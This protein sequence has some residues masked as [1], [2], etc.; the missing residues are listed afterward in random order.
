[1]LLLLA[2]SVSAFAQTAN[3]PAKAQ[4]RQG[5]AKIVKALDLNKDQAKQVRDIVAKLHQDVANV[6]KS[7]A[8]KD[9]KKAQIKDLRT[10]AVDAVMAI[11][12]PD[13]QTKAKKMNLEQMI[14]A[15]SSAKR[16]GVMYALSQLNLTDQQKASI[17]S[18]NEDSRKAAKAIQDD[19]SL[20]K[21]AKRAKLA[22]LKKSTEDKVVA[23]LTPDQQQKLKD[24]LAKEKQAAKD[25]EKSK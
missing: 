19:T 10:K 23:V 3:A 24:I 11:L 20:D 8:T 5:V 22:D 18:I 14:M 6:V 21:A 17:K 16:I 13:Q 15:P 2:V 4:P 9:Q 25:H 7:T 1:M 12:T